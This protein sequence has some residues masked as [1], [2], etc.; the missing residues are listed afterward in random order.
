MLETFKLSRLI[1]RDF[2]LNVGEA[3]PPTFKGKALGTRLTFDV[4]SL[5]QYARC[6]LSA[7]LWLP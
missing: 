6:L 1:S 2:P 7:L 3:P 4:I 5:Q